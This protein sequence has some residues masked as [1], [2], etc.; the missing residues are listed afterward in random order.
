LSISALYQF[1]GLGQQL[2]AAEAVMMGATRKVLVTAIG[3]A[4]GDPTSDPDR[5]SGA[6]LNQQVGV[7]CQLP[8]MTRGPYPLANARSAQYILL[9]SRAYYEQVVHQV[10]HSLARFFLEIDANYKQFKTASRLRAAAAKRLDAQRTYY[11]EGRITIDRFLDAVS[12]YATAV[13]TEAQYKTAYNVSIVALEEAKGT[14]LAYD[15]IVIAEGP[16]KKKSYAKATVTSDGG[17]SKQDKQVVATSATVEPPKDCTVPPTG[18][19]CTSESAKPA[20][21][22]QSK[23]W[24]FSIAIGGAHPFEIKGT[25]TAGEAA[26]APADR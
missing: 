5:K 12:Q 7:M 9:R 6:F 4:A 24:S 10:T 22:S 13:A 23:T 1:N 8:L 19:A 3:A 26:P 20:A 2:D 14:L 15:N 18:T 11:E 21:A 16:R 17:P 25:I